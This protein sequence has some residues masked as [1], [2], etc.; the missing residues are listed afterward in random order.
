MQNEKIIEKILCTLTERFN[1]IMC[2]IEESK[3]I[4]S[5]GLQSSLLVHEQKY[6]ENIVE[7]QTL[8]VT[9]GEQSRAKEEDRFGERGRGRGNSRRRGRGQGRPFN[10]SIVECYRC[11][12]LGH[13]STNAL[14]M[15]IMQ[16]ILK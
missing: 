7:D 1:Y 4:N 14:V 2:S 12:K 3:D 5:T 10:K 9:E 16:N 15:L 13:L 11:H 8:K 6:Q